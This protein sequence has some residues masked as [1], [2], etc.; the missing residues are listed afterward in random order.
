MQH[1]RIVAGLALC[2]ASLPVLAAAPAYLRGSDCLD[3]NMARSWI[4]LDNRTI[5]VDAGRHKYRMEI[6]GACSALGFS[7]YL[8]FK[9]D[10]ISGRV[11]GILSDSIVTRD[12]TCRIERMELLDKE[13]YKQALES[14]KSSRRRKPVSHS[15]TP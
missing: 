5:L 7:P 4:E 12:Y 3:P 9:G 1:P 10:P 13:Q 14:R 8:G 6:S 15:G 2:L 11:C